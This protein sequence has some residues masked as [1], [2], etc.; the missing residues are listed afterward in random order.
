MTKQS[1]G[2]ILK[3]TS[4]TLKQYT[5]AKKKNQL[6]LTEVNGNAFALMAAFQS[7]AKR[8]EWDK[9]EIK[10]VLDECRKGDYDHLLQTLI[11]VCD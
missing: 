11:S 2:E 9:D 6:D 10:T 4:K 1:T 8:E 5:M 3:K 7:Q